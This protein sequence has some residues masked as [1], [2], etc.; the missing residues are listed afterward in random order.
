MEDPQEILEGALDFLEAGEPEEAL[1]RLALL[2]EED[3][4]RWSTAAL[5]AIELGELEQA[6]AAVER[7]R[8]R[9]AADDPELAWAEGR[10]HLA[11]WRLAEARAAFLRIAPED[12]VSM[13]SRCTSR[14]VCTCCRT[15]RTA[16]MR[17]RT[18]ARRGTRTSPCSPTSTA[19]RTRRTGS[20]PRPAG[21]TRRGTRRRRASRR[22]SSRPSSRRPPR[23]CRTSSAMRSRSLPS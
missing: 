4:V 23:P 13:P 19:T 3:G 21:S 9:L 11:S 10:V 14:G 5:A 2:P 16:P 8:E 22:R 20:S 15:T 6:E 17:P 18:G 1:A 12:G 7:A